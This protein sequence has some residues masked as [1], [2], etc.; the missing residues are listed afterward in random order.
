[1]GIKKTAHQAAEYNA[2]I[3]ERKGQINQI[4]ALLEE[5]TARYGELEDRLNDLQ[6]TINGQLFEKQRHTEILGRKQKSLKRYQALERGTR[7]PLL[8]AEAPRVEE[9]LDI[10][11]NK[12]MKIKGLLGILGGNSRTSRMCSVGCPSSRTTNES[13]TSTAGVRGSHGSCGDV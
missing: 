5:E 7:T 11:E 13:K 8:D 10:E 9:D 6:T 4:S 1:M 2:A 3:D 12:A